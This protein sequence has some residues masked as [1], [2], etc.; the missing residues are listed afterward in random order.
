MLSYYAHYYVICYFYNQWFPFHLDKILSHLNQV[1][2][3]ISPI[4]PVFFCICLNQYHYIW[5]LSFKSLLI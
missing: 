1:H 4:D 5:L 3:H 2:I